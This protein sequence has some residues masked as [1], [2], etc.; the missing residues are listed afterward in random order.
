MAILLIAHCSLLIGFRGG[1][2]EYPDQKLFVLPASYGWEFIDWKNIPRQEGEEFF[3]TFEVNVWIY[4]VVHEIAIIFIVLG[5]IFSNI[6]ILNQL[7]MNQMLQVSNH[8]FCLSR[9]K[10]F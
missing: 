4:L 7:K 8:F 1:F 3:V 9:D 5:N 10:Q 2:D 6:I